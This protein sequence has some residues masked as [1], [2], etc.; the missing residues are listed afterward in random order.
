VTGLAGRHA[1]EFVVTWGSSLVRKTYRRVYRSKEWARGLA[2]T[3]GGITLML[4]T[5]VLTSQGFTNDANASVLA[6][7]IV[8]AVGYFLLFRVAGS[9]IIVTDRGV[10]VRNP[11]GT[12]A[13]R[14]G[15][16]QRFSIEQWSIFPGIGTVELRG[17]RPLRVF[18]VQIPDPRFGRFDHQTE[19]TIDELNGLLRERGGYE[20]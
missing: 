4:L 20:G 2:L 16:I 1:K 17:A 8:A 3:G 19:R 18:G 10:V 9:A 12:R 7:S 5:R 6:L 13:V 14:W 11:L 15:D